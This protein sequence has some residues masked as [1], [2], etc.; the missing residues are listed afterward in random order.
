MLSCQGSVWIYDVSY[1]ISSF[2]RHRPTFPQVKKNFTWTILHLHRLHLGRMSWLYECGCE[3]CE[4]QC[5]PVVFVSV[6][7][8][9]YVYFHNDR[10][11]TWFRF[12]H[13]NCRYEQEYNIRD[14]TVAKMQNK[15]AKSIYSSLFWNRAYKKKGKRTQAIKYII[16]I[17]NRRNNER[18]NWYI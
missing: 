8:Q 2:A 4:A 15:M 9:L 6:A 10:E 5:I 11:S 1:V 7:V 17:T 12:S 18:L 13:C 14:V 3:W 16:D